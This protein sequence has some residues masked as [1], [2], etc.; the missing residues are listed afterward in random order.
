MSCY[1]IRELWGYRFQLENPSHSTDTFILLIFH[2]NSLC[3]VFSWIQLC[4]YCFD[5]TLVFATSFLNL[6]SSVLFMY[7]SLYRLLGK[8]VSST[9]LSRQCWKN[10]QSAYYLLKWTFCLQEN[11]FSLLQRETEKLRGDI[12]KMRSE[13]KSVLNL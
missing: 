1:F 9:Y 4:S 7:F 10:M 13:L 6:D 12:D 5:D 3:T 2:V 8:C 11:H